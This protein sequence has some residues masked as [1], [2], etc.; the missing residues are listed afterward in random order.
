L[1]AEGYDYPL[2]TLS[3][4]TELETWVFNEQGA[5]TGV[6]ANNEGGLAIFLDLLYFKNSIL[7][8]MQQ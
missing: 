5:V 2:G 8:A 3:F 4:F 1:T 7:S 6:V